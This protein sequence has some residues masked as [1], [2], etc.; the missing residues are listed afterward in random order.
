MMDF[1]LG[2]FQRLN[3]IF[4]YVLF[5]IDGHDF[6]IAL[7]AW[8]TTLIVLIFWGTNKVVYLLDRKLLVRTRLSGGSRYALTSIIRYLSLTVGFLFF[9]SEAGFDFKTLTVVLGALGVGIGFGLQSI[10]NNFLSGI[11]ILIEQ[12][13]S[14]GDRVEIEGIEGNVVSINP[15]SSTI[16]TNDNVNHIVPNGELISKR[17]INWTHNNNM[18]RR[19]IPIFVSYDSDPDKVTEVL[20]DVARETDGV[21]ENP[22]PDVL[23]SGFEES[24]LKFVLRVWTVDLSSQPGVLTSKLNHL[25]FKKFKE[26]DIKIPYPQR[27]VHLM[28]RHD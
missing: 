26:N 12:T 13:V 7:I 11:I 18:V 17:V 28:N 21:L 9:L 15:R 8:L 1:F 27:D 3:N 5:S 16:K 22:V 14:I 23:F 6:T 19:R 24:S 2:N 25:I 4:N 20:M 10:F